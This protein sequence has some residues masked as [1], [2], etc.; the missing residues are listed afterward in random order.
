MPNA[1]LMVIENA[2]RLGLAQLHQLRGRVGRG[3]DASFCV[4]MYKT[5]LSQNGKARLEILRATNDGFKIAEKDLELRG[6]GQIY[7]VKQ[8][9]AWQLK[10]ADL[11]RDKDILEQVN[12]AM[13]DIKDINIINKLIDRWVL[14]SDEYSKI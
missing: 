11:I 7:G 2:E 14:F 12:N 13:N 1:T 4:L 5:P 9:G 3:S 8:T 10:I 6:F